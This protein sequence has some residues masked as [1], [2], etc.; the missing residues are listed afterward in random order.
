MTVNIIFILFQRSRRRMNLLAPPSSSPTLV[1][2]LRSPPRFEIL[3]QGYLIFG[4]WYWVSIFGIFYLVFNIWYLSN[5]LTP[6]IVDG[7]FAALFNDDDVVVDFSK[8]LKN[9]QRDCSEFFFITFQ[10]GMLFLLHYDVAY[11]TLQNAKLLF[12]YFN[13]STILGS[14]DLFN[15]FLL[16]QR[17]SKW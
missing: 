14:Y 5:I 11:F 12:L 4:I 7:S 3:W 15:S 6:K 13:L 8:K 10:R 17:R 1:Q 16:L 9:M 2:T